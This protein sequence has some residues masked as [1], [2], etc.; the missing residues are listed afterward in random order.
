MRAASKVHR[1]ARL[2]IAQGIV[3]QVIE[4]HLQAVGVGLDQHLRRR[5]HAQVDLAAVGQRAMVGHGAGQQLA[6]VDRAQLARRQRR[7]V[8]GQAQ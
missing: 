1:A 3:D 4:Q 7:F 8:A 2:R 5:H 6:Q